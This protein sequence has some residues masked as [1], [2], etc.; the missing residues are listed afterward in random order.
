MPPE[1]LLPPGT[2]S[3]LMGMECLNIK[4]P[5]SL[6]T[7]LYAAQRES[8]SKYVCLYL[9]RHAIL[10]VVRQLRERGGQRGDLPAA[11]QTR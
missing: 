1:S 9:F 3:V 2:G 6:P 7:L 5:G 8:K 4:F 10:P 11:T